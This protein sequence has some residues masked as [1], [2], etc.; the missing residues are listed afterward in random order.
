MQ[1]WLNPPGGATDEPERDRLGA[2]ATATQRASLPLACS[3]LNAWGLPRETAH[4]WLPGYIKSRL[5]ALDRPPATDVWVVFADHFEP[6]WAKADLQTARRRVAG[7]RAAWPEIAARHRDSD[8]RPPCYAFF[9]PEEEYRPELLEPLAEMARLGIADVEVHLH[10]DQDTEAAFRDRLGTFLQALHRDHGLL[11]LADGL[12][13]FAFIH[14][15]WCLD[16]SRP[17]GRWCGLNNEI[18]IL[19][20]MGCYAD[21]TLPAAPDPSQTGLVNVIYRATDDPARPGSH[22]SGVPI[23]AGGSD[24]GDLTLIPGPSGARLDRASVSQA[25]ARHWRGGRQSPPIARARQAVARGG[26]ADR[27]AHLP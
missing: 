18:T 2:E 17:D 23:V 26:T 11:R 4:L 7:W 5:R 21:F 13:R 6:L 10:H 12:I 8:G 15:N 27:F 22:G 1:P 14:G 19:R 24:D 3:S 9:Y 16:N 25:A 20:E